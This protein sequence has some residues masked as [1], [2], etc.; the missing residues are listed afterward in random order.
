MNRFSLSGLG[1]ALLAV[2]LFASPGCSPSK[3]DSGGRIDPYETTT[4]DRRSPK[5]SLPSLLEFGDKA[6]QQLAAD[7]I[8]ID[9]IQGR[10]SRAVLELGTI[11]NKT[12]TPTQDFEQLQLRL[13]NALR[14]SKLIRDQFLVVESG[15]RAD[16]EKRRTTGDGPTDLLQEGAGATGTNRYNA[17]DTFVLQGDFYES[18]RGNRSQFYLAFQLTN[19]QTREIVFTHDYDLGQVEE[20]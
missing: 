12:K 9:Q 2:G 11:V 10:K 18:K 6:A 17:E 14:K 5:A 16:V 13:R 3:G 8:D 19:V 7:L 20:K 4:Y 1:A 15:A